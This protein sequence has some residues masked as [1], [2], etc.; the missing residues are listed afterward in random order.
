MVQLVNMKCK[1]LWK[2]VVVIRNATSRNLP[3]GTKTTKPHGQVCVERDSKKAPT[4]A[5]P[6]NRR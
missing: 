5:R 2:E 4:S 3:A 1:E 6:L